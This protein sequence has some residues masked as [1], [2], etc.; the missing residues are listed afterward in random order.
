MTRTI[1]RMIAAA[2][3]GFFIPTFASAQLGPLPPQQALKRGAEVFASTCAGYCHGDNG[4]VGTS[5]P[6]L[7][8]RG[9]DPQYIERVVMY[10]VAGT[11]MPGWGQKL[12]VPDVSAV[13]TY[14]K[15]LNGVSALS[16]TAPPP[17][18]S[19]E[20]QRGRDL[21]YDAAGELKT[22]S[23]CHRVNDK[24][25]AVVSQ[26]VNVPADVPGLSSLIT[27]HVS[28]ATVNGETFPALIVTQSRD[29]TKLY[30]LTKVPPV[31]RSFP[32]SVAVKISDGS[33]WRH[34]SVLGTYSDDDLR[35]ILEFLH[36]V[37]RP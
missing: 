21:F 9:L 6:R 35:S 37:Q 36:G 12:P 11:L 26:I 24:G 25:L 14:V 10:G 2:L 27:S 8:G 30:D 15:S 32:S 16:S 20:A 19:P 4:A 3:L 28:T 33:S 13:I 29:G 17:S 22:C 23:N 34:S 18:L 7:A 1:G 31:L 5:A